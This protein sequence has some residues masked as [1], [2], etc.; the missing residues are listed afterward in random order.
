M[1]ATPPPP[2][3]VSPHFCQ[4]PLP[5]PGTGQLQDPASSN[6]SNEVLESPPDGTRVSPLAGQSR[7]F[8]QQP[9]I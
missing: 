1:A 4:V 8:L 6:P 3:G 9:L 2:G 7:G 5:E